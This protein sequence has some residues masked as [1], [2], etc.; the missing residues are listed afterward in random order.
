MIVFLYT[1]PVVIGFLNPLLYTI[2]VVVGE[3]KNVQIDHST[4]QLIRSPK[5]PSG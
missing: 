3:L 1:I 2:L 4:H 5:R